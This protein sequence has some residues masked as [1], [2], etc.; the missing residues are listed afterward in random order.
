MESTPAA[1]IGTVEH[2]AAVATTPNPAQILDSGHRHTRYAVAV[3][4]DK[5]L[6]VQKLIDDEN[7]EDFPRRAHGTRTVTD[8]AS[9]LAE[10]DRRPLNDGVGTLWGN[11]AR[12]EIVAIYND[13]EG[14]ESEGERLP[15]WRDD[16]LVLKLPPHPDWVQWHAI[17]GKYFK[18]G[19]FGDV[20]EELR[21]TI[22]QPDQADLLEII[23]SIRAS[24]KGDFESTVNRSNGG[25]KVGYKKEISTRAGAV[26][27][28]LEV[29]Q[30]ILL[31][32]T[33]WDGHEQLY[34]VPAYFR[35][36]ITEG[37]LQLAIKLF[38]TRELV[39]TAWADLTKVIVDTI[40]KPVY[41]QP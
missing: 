4:E 14:S 38:P 5:G 40:G 10:L 15:G 29:P 23:D 2:T 12:G 33:P 16:K 22:V 7:E 41:A 27:R 25:L 1:T 21:H 11:A 17:S 9:F 24:L 30:N 34:E 8:V 18:Q 28:E 3:T 39:R 35:L 37:Q 13:H 26:G 20:I 31:S 36:D 32:I 6:Q 19:Q